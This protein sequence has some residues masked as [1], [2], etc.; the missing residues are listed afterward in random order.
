[1]KTTKLLNTLGPLALAFALGACADSPKAPDG[2]NAS[3][4]PTA[5]GTASE[6]SAATPSPAA[7]DVA[8]ATPTPAPTPLPPPPPAADVRAAVARVYKG[9]VAADERAGS[10]VVGDF[11]GDGSEDLVVRVR[12]VP[13]R[14]DDLNEELANWIVTDPRKVERPDPRKFDP[15]QGVQKLTP[16]TERPHIAATDSLLVV[17]HGYKEAGWRNAEASQTYLLKD[18]G[19]TDLRTQTRASARLTTL[20]QNPPR[21]MG[22]VIRETLRDEQ[23]FLYWNGATYGWFSPGTDK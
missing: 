20:G 16:T 5:Q 11:N 19:G 14:V 2:A 3:P 12:A 15:H 9:S 7:Q 8:A 4:A 22:D 21:L 1:M 18:V 23:G 17:I 13:G 10:A 6:S